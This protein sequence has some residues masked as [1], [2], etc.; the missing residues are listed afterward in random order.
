MHKPLLSY[1]IFVIE[2]MQFVPLIAAQLLTSGMALSM[3]PW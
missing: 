3:S 2:K 1:V